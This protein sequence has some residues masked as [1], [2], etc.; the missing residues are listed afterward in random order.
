MTTKEVVEQLIKA[1]KEDQEYY[2]SWQANIAM[3]FQDEFERSRIGRYMKNNRPKWLE[4]ITPKDSSPVHY[5]ANNAAKNFLDQLTCK[6][7][8]LAEE[9]G[10]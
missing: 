10:L 5:I 9:E 7:C 8:E 4:D 3:A 6:Y 1:L 2:Y